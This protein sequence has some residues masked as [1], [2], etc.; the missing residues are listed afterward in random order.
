[1]NVTLHVG[2][3]P[4]LRHYVVLLQGIAAGWFI[5]SESQLSDIPDEDIVYCTPHGG[6]YGQSIP[7][8]REYMG[9]G[10]SERDLE[11]LQERSM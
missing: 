4:T 10:I 6:Y 5:V 3:C 2:I 11:Y 1:M 9:E 8:D 7:E